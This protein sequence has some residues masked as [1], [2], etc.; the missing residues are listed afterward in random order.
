MNLLFQ[1]PILFVVIIG[2]LLMTLSFHE[3]AHAYI[4]YK[5]GD[6]TAERMGRMTL[7]PLAHID[8]VGFLMILLIG[9][10]YAKP[11]PFNPVLLKYR[12][13][14]PAFVAAAGPISNL[15]LGI[16]CSVAYG[17][18]FPTFG[19]DNLLIIAL[20][21]LGIINFALMVFN[22]IPIPPLDGS[23]VLLAVLADH[24]YARIRDALETKGSLIL[25]GL[26][27]ADIFLGIGI[28]SWIFRISNLLF[29]FFTFL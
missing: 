26:I 6:P 11:V 21:F 28:F 5:L 24:K 23:K 27:F 20:F 18:L 8:P 2:A 13:W 7:N 25:L 19:P 9:F 29:D 14:G 12:T 1:E 17:L 4:G 3:F 15:I 22:L 16:I 10:G